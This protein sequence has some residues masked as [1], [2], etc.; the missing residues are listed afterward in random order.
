MEVSEAALSRAFE[1]IMRTDAWRSKMAAFSQVIPELECSQGRPD[2]VACA[3]DA[4]LCQP[5]N[6]NQILTTPSFVRILSVLKRGAPRTQSFV[7]RATGLDPTVVDRRMTYLIKHGVIQ[8]VRPGSFVLAEDL[9]PVE[10]E[11]WAFE[12]KL[13]DWR[14]AQFQV[15]Q[16]RAFAHRATIVIAQQWAHRIERHL[17]VFV[18]FGIGI[19]VVNDETEQ[20]KILGFP[21]RSNPSSRFHYLYAMGKFLGRADRTPEREQ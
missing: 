10:P 3:Y 19:V 15:L 13:R 16:Y 8:E 5:A 6:F 17:P 21:K 9:L 18:Q 7:T 20:F 2:F 12:V 4:V 14:R 11:L 1:N